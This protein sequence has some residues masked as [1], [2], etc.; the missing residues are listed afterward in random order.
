MDINTLKQYGIDLCDN[1]MVVAHPDDESLWG[2]GHLISKNWFIICLT[3]GDNNIRSE[4]FYKV[5]N[6]TGNHGIIL[7]YPDEICGI[8]DDW[9]NYKS[10]I[11]N[12]LSLTLDYKNWDK[13]VTHNPD[14]DTGHIHHKITNGYVY[15]LC[16]EKNLLNHLYYFGIFYKEGNIPENLSKMNDEQIN[17]KKSA[18]A[19]YKHEQGPINTFWAQMIPYENWIP[20]NDWGLDE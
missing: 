6:Y 3:N 11:I 16:K 8:R 14:G 2:G 10:E 20:S 18:L 17:F 1:L 9:K 15:D 12:I 13:I 5:L 4:E 7:N 19:I